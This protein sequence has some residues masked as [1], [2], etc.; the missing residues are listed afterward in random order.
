MKMIQNCFRVRNS[1]TYNIDMLKSLVC[2]LS[3]NDLGSH[4]TK[5]MNGHRLMLTDEL[6]MI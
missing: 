1:Y 6:I 4:L 2:K 5:K 3:E